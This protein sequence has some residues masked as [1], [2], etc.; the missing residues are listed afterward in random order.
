MW[1]WPR[2]HVPLSP[3][4]FTYRRETLSLSMR[5]QWGSWDKMS[6]VVIPDPCGFI[7]AHINS[8][9]FKYHMHYGETMLDEIRSLPSGARS[10]IITQA[11]ELMLWWKCDQRLGL[12]T[13]L[14]FSP[15]LNLLLLPA[16][17]HSEVDIRKP[18]HLPL[19]PEGHRKGRVLGKSK[20]ENC[21]RRSRS[22]FSVEV[23][24]EGVGHTAP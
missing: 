11:G 24:W 22:W 14:P 7:L 13:L 20:K 9:A 8:L 6:Y 21:Q 1:L 4:F 16:P 5:L 15:L 2:H 12:V 19:C 3:R 17:F 10:I 18:E 23:S